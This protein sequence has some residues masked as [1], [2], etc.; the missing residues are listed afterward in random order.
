MGHLSPIA[1][2]NFIHKMRL[3]ICYSLCRK[4][5]LMPS[6]NWPLW[7]NQLFN[8]FPN[9]KRSRLIYITLTLHHGTKH[10][11]QLL[12]Q[13]QL[14]LGLPWAESKPDLSQTRARS[15]PASALFCEYIALSNYPHILPY[16]YNPPKWQ[17][18][19]FCVGSVAQLFFFPGSATR[20]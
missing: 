11:V 2:D 15:V 4:L 20:D 9:H 19:C 10:H 7:C 16:R 14:T 12:P 3:D 8:H 17:S 18:L 5:V 1:M 13:Y 6:E